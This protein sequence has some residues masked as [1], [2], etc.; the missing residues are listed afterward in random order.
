L[1]LNNFTKTSG[2]CV[3]AAHTPFFALFFGKKSRF[4]PSTYENTP[5]GQKRHFFLEKKRKKTSFFRRFLPRRMKIRLSVRSDI[6]FSKK[7]AKNHHRGKRRFFLKEAAKR[8]FSFE[9]LKCSVGFC[10]KWSIRVYS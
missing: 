4:L 3:L 7:S 2:V 8:M 9:L 6:F 5:S 10:A 1:K